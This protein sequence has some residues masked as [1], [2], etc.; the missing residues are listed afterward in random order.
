MDWQLAS[1]NAPYV[2]IFKEA[3]KA[4]AERAPSFAADAK[5]L[6]AQLDL[7]NGAMTGRQWVAGGAMSLADICLG[8]IIARCLDFPIDVS[9]LEA[10]KAWRG[11]V[12]A[13]PAFKKATG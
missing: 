2:A 6:K 7:L 10:L 11:T 1:L 9:G 8:P 5:E 4:E 12:A 3:K 13:R